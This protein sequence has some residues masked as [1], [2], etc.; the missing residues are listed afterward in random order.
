MKKKRWITLFLSALMLVGGVGCGGGSGVGKGGNTELTIWITATNQPQYFLGWFK[1]AFETENPNIT[2]NFVTQSADKLSSGLDAALAGSNAP[3]MASTWGGSSLN[4]TLSGGNILQIDDVMEKYEE[5]LIDAALLNKYEGHHYV[6]P[7][8]GFTSPVVYYNKTVFDQNGWTAP[9]TYE[10]LKTLSQAITA[11]KTASGAQRYQT[12][13]TG[14]T[15]HLMMAI[16]ARTCTKEQLEKLATA[17]SSDR[18]LYDAPGFSNGFSWVED[19]RDDKVL[20]ENCSGYN[21]GTASNAFTLQ[22]ALMIATTSLDLLELSN[23]AQFEIGAFLF[24]DAPEKYKPAYGADATENGPV[25]GVYTDSFVINANKSEAEIAACKKVVDFLY[26]PAAQSKLFNYYLYPVR[27]DV[28]YEGVESA[29]QAVFDSTMKGIY[30]RAKEDGMGIFYMTYFYKNGIMGNLES[31]VKQV[32][33]GFAA[34]VGYGSVKN[35][36]D[37]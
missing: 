11:I 28:G 19:M 6:A 17:T 31:G 2:L 10:E 4:G 15:Y 8:F 35:F 32:L 9:S 12:I 25:T 18:G 1:N 37:S 13:V 29:N 3:H 30:E 22:S 21:E 7:I 24:P 23:N 14:Y 27:K 36:I 20:A 5:H 34:G 26:G 16:H 33:N